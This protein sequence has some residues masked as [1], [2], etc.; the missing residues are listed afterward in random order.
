MENVALLETKLIFQGGDSPLPPIM[1][2]IYLVVSISSKKMSQIK[3]FP[4]GWGVRIEK[5]RP[6]ALSFN[7]VDSKSEPADSLEIVTL[8]GI[9]IRQNV[10]TLNFGLCFFDGWKKIKHSPTKWSLNGI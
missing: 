9:L 3:S 10:R 6:P 1:E 8:E 5:K 7:L 2:S 4:K